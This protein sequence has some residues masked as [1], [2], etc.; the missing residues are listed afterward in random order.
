MTFTQ[1]QYAAL[2]EAISQ[3]VKRVKYTD[4]EVEYQSLNEMLALKSKMEIDL[5]VTP[6]GS[7]SSALGLKIYPQPDKGL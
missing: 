3:G 4:K 5:G 6:T 7:N 1:A 2:V